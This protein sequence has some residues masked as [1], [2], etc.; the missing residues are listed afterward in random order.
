MLLESE[1]YNLCHLAVL[2]LHHILPRHHRLGQ[3]IK[4]HHHLRHKIPNNHHFELHQVHRTAVIHHE[5]SNKLVILD[6][7]WIKTEPLPQAAYH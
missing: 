4:T 2:E 1:A 3:N 5:N 7:Q 6:I